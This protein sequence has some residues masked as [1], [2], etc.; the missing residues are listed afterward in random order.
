MGGCASGR[1]YS[2][3]TCGAVAPL[4]FARAK[5]MRFFRDNGLSMVLTLLFLGL[6]VGHSVA[7]HRN[8]NEE[9][10]IEGKAT[11]SYAEYLRSGDFL[12]S[13]F[14]NWESEFFQMAFYVVLTVFLFQKGS[15]ESKDPDEPHEV[16][17]DPRRIKPKP[18]TPGP[19]R[20]GGWKLVL[21]EYSLSLAF[22]ILFLV[23]FAGHGFFGVEPYNEERIKAGE[24]PAS[25]LEYMASSRFWFESFQNWQSEFLAVLAIVVLSVFLRQRG[26][27][28]SKPVAAPHHETGSG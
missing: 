21:Y 7:G 8:H 15:S 28:E 26:S 24:P 14:E 27:P 13:V 5:D 23:S 1:A 12:E 4:G 22:V 3:L 19:V 20:A 2:K 25:V 17:Q 6:L 11:L 9:R 16:D 18:S 10:Q